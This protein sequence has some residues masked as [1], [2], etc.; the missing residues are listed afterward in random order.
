MALGVGF[1]ICL[2]ALANGFGMAYLDKRAEDK[3]KEDNSDIQ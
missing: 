3:N 1:I 2:F